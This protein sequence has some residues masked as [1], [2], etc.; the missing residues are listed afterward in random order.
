MM[1]VETNLLGT[2]D[3]VAEAIAAIKKYEPAN[4]YHV[5]FSGGKDSQ[6]VWDLV[7]LAGVKA[8]A[9]FNLT[10]VDPPELIRFIRAHYPEVEI[11]K[12]SR[13]MYRLIVRRLM[14]PTRIMRFCCEFLKENSGPGEDTGVT[15]TGVR[16]AESLIRSKRGLYEKSKKN[17]KGWILN[18]IIEWSDAD[19][20]E[21]IRSNKMPYCSLYDEGFSRVGCVMCP[22]AG[23]KRMR[24]D[25][26]RWP[27]IANIYRMAFSKVCEERKRLGKEGW[28]SGAEMFEWWIGD[29]KPVNHVC[30]QREFT[31]EDQ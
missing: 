16:K 26:A 23:P 3:R 7:K 30:G 15:I 4:G 5:G 14:A 20:W 25:A 10:T 29:S 1:L 21:Y 24:S 11:R 2:T 6:V 27:N 17:K 19:V 22:M 12:P 9:V 18:P 28:A 31:F 8:E 13:S